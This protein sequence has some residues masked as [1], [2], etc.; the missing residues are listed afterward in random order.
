MV[1]EEE[2]SLTLRKGW[3]LGY[4]AAKIRLR[5]V[6][7]DLIDIARA[8]QTRA[9]FD[10]DNEVRLRNE[11]IESVLIEVSREMVVTL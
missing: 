2:E 10:G 9:A 8:N 11:E 7:N 3:G 1:T 4:T 5:Y 6:L